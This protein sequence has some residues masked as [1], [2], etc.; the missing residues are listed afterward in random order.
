MPPVHSELLKQ[1]KGI[2][3][4]TRGVVDSLFA[5]ESRSVFRGQGMEFAEVR[6]YE[7]G[8]DFRAIDWNVSAR[9]G[10]P[11]VK[12]FTEERELTLLL[13]V[14]Q[15]AS[16]RVGVPVTKAA[17]SVEVAAVLALAGVREQDRVGGLLFSDRVEHVVPPAKGRRH[18]LRLIRDLLAFSSSGRGTNLVEAIRY[19]SNVL[20]HRSVVVILSDFLAEGWEKAL[21]EL[22][23]R[24]EVIAITVDDPREESP[25]AAGWVE[26]EDAENGRRALVNTGSA[27]A[28]KRWEAAVKARRAQRADRLRTAGVEHI[29]LDVSSDYGMVLRRAFAKRIRRKGTR[30]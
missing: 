22:A 12:T 26:M 23:V 9:L 24:H 28:R 20:S 4:R 8:D 25:P 15:S 2:T 6:A 30:R 7:H 11:Y 13:M 29:A 19:A 1:V 17:R 3:L 10:A 5:G 16:T 21:R 27:R 14:D 18:A